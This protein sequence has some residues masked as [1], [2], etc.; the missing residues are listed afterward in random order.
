VKPLGSL[1]HPLLCGVDRVAVRRFGASFALS[2][3]NSFPT[4]YIN[5]GKKDKGGRLR[6]FVHSVSVE[7]ALKVRRDDRLVTHK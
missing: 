7:E 3:S 6:E 4:G 5:G 2:E 1:A